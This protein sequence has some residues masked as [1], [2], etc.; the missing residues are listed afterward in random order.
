MSIILA[1]VLGIVFTVMGL[2][3]VINKKG[4]L[5]MIIEGSNNQGLW[6]LYGC[7]ALI[8]GALLI[9]FNNVWGFGLQLVGTIFG[10]IALLKGAFILLFPNYSV[11]FYKKVCKSNI[12][13]LAGIVILILG[14]VLLFYSGFI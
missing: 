3:L 1:E 8:I 4:V 12:V 11:S 9:A 5:T 13:F 6:W 14:V 7:I 2:S 10:W